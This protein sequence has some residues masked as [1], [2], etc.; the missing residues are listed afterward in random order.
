[1][2]LNFKKITNNIKYFAF[3]LG[4]RKVGRTLS[5]MNL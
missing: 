3:F 4:E 5:V 1:M 2:S